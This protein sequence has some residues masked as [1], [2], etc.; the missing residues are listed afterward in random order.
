MPTK[1][2]FVPPILRALFYIALILITGITA[3]LTAKNIPHFDP[4]LIFLPVIAY[5]AMMGGFIL[6]LFTTF[7]CVNIAILMLFY[8]VSHPFLEADISFFI[9]LWIFLFVGIFVSY[10]IYISK[11]YEKLIEYQRRLRQAHKIIDTLE[12]NYDIAKTEIKAR[13][14][15]LAI[16]SHEL[17]T[18]V[19]SMLLE[20]QS[21]IHNIK[22]VSLANFSVVTLL[23]MLE[24]TEQQ[25]KRLSKMVN[26]LL[27]LSLITTGKIDLEPEHAN[28]SKIVTDV[29]ERSTA[30]LTDKKQLNLVIQ[31]PVMGYCD[32]FRIEQA[33]VNLVSNAIKYGNNKPI[34]ITA[35][36]NSENVRIVVADRGIGIPQDQ[37]K[38][39]FNR[40]ERAVTSRDYK[41]L[42]VGLYITYQIVKAHN[43]R[44]HVESYP[45]K[46]SV[47][48][49]EFPIRKTTI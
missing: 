12:R 21:A 4:F 3:E 32:K 29:V 48:T 20:V 19:T 28:I 1:S 43:G 31:N 2:K 39:I 24:D 30:R 18:P 17:K 5:C 37:Q 14:Q 23:K 47:F 35:S 38:R 49:I 44:I 10:I 27:D 15:F 6:G 25:S 40:F 22:N 42:G 36:G 26:D 46:G 16:A 34:T 8:P 11:Q 7:I 13:D 9:Q 33:V 41:G 45:N